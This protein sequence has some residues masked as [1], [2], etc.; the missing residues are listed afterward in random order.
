MFYLIKIKLSLSIFSALIALFLIYPALLFS[1][2]LNIQLDVEP[3]V[4]TTVEQNLDFGQVIGGA[5]LQS[6][7]PGS[8][9]MGIFQI[10]AL[11]TQQLIIQ[12]EEVEELQHEDPDVL[13]SIPIELRASY[14]NFGIEDFE[15]STPLNSI[16]ESVVLQT[17]GENP[18]S[19]WTSLYVYVYGDVDIGQVREGLYTGEV[20]LTVIYE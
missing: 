11:R 3:R 17:S 6:I 4:E 18:E 9:E 20:V 14:T 5:G 7:L 2:S 16:G 15:L 13:D 12:M 19:E 10:R 8:P 1:Q